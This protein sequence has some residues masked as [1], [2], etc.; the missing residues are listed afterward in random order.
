[1]RDDACRLVHNQQLIVFIQ[2]IEQAF[3]RQNRRGAHSVG[4]LDCHFVA[5]G[6][7]RGHSLDEMTVDG[8]ATGFDPRLHSRSRGSA[9]V[10]E[11]SSKNEIDTAS[12]VAA[13]GYNGSSERRVCHLFMV[14]A[15]SSFARIRNS[16][17]SGRLIATS[18]MRSGLH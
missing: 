11:M 3:L 16:L 18:S 7:A 15:A 12:S 14:A 4:E 1:M 9:N 2:A 5:E 10:G 8:H 17:N 13:I 6:S